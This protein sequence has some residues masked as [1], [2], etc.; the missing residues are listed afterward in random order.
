MSCERGALI[1]FYK[2]GAANK[3][4]VVF[5]AKV[6]IDLDEKV[7]I[8]GVFPWKISS[9]QFN[10]TKNEAFVACTNT[11]ANSSVQPGIAAHRFGRKLK[12]RCTAKYKRRKFEK[13][14]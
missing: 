3:F 14:K 4:L 5:K 13:Q 2:V 8:E 10:G 6:G 1:H 12:D 7:I 11:T 9:S